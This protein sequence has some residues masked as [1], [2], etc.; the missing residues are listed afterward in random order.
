[1]KTTRSVLSGLAR[2][3]FLVAAFLA[4]G[5]AFSQQSSSR[6]NSLKAN[7][8]SAAIV[9]W[10]ERS[11]EKITDF[12]AYLNLLSQESNKEL[13]AQISQNIEALFASE[14]VSVLDF[15][16]SDKKTNLA[17][18]LQTVSG[19]K[20]RFDVSGKISYDN[21]SGNS[22]TVSYSLEVLRNGAKTVIPIVQTIRLSPSRKSFGNSDK[23]VWQQVLGEMK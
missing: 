13:K 3:S 8:S 12:Y 4:F 16:G 23:V 6:D 21:L 19:S 22:W 20:T 7:F 2:I 15:F 10:Q 1:M 11:A 18:L 14:N 17:T 9:A 5:S